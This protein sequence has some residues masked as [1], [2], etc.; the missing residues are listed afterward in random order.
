M[1]DSFVK[2]QAVSAWRRFRGDTAGSVLVVAGLMLVALIAFAGMATDY[3]RIASV[4]SQLQR[5]ADAATLAAV[6]SSSEVVDHALALNGSGQVPGGAEFIKTWFDAAIAN[7]AGD[8]KPSA[9]ATVARD[10]SNLTATL[11][12]TAAVPAGFLGVIGF[13]SFKIRG[14]SKAEA[15]IASDMDFYLLLDNSPSMGVGATPADIATMVANTPDACAFACHD[16]SDPNNYYLLAK[17]IGVTTRIGVLRKATQNLMDTAQSTASHID[18]YRTA[19]YTFNR[20]VQ[21]ISKLTSNLTAAQ[22]SAAAIDLVTVPKQNDNNDEYTD[23]P[24]AL[25]HMNNI[26]PDSGSGAR[27]SPQQ[28]LFFVTDGVG[29][30]NVKGTR[31]IAPIDTAL[32]QQIKD[33]GIKIAVLY[34]TYLPL[35]TNQFYMDNVDPWVATI[36]PMMQSC[37]SPGLFFEVSPSEGISEAMNALFLKVTQEAH[38]TN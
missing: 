33:R 11:D 7:G 6:A 5:A 1:Q 32:C 38:L 18:Q 2:L 34:T 36:S 29:D 3:V 19:I 8:Y 23:F 31:T 20:N 26:M 9:T 13:R 35:P 4:E 28:V 37:A 27:G 10:K 16:L 25:K 24:G 21:Q 17:R 15:Q 30:S 14:V 12:Y 22:T